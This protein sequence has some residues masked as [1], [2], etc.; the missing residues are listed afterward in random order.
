MLNKE[1]KLSEHIFSLLKEEKEQS[2]ANR[3]CSKINY[4]ISIKNQGRIN[5]IEKEI[6]EFD[7]SARSGEFKAAKYALLDDFEM[8]SEILENVIDNGIPASSIEN[9]P[10]FL[11]Y[12]ETE[13]YTQF[14][15][16]H[17]DL[18]AIQ[19]YQPEYIKIDSDDEE[20]IEVFGEQMESIDKIGGK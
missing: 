20:L 1:W 2:E 4:W 8:V 11:Q 15:N 3:I 6:Q 10:L 7:I 19:D 13:N 5:E 17:K 18:F 16:A 9:W 12:R 14:R